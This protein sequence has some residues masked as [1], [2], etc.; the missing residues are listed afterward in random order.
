MRRICPIIVLAVITAAL[1]ALFAGSLVA[2]PMGSALTYQGQLQQSN[3]PG[4]IIGQ[5]ASGPV[6]AVCDFRFSL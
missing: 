4:N 6:T 3:S 2:A 5:P 1:S